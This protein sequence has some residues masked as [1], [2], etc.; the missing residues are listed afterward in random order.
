MSPVVHAGFRPA[1]RLRPLLA[2]LCAAAL[3]ALGACSGASPEPPLAGAA[4]GGDFTLIDK[5]GKTV[6]AADFAGRYRVVYF[7]YTF[8]PDVCPLD[9]QHLMQGVHAFAK[10]QPALGAKLAPM[11]ITIDPARDTPQV[12]GEFAANFG[13]ELIGLTGTPA[14]VA[15]VAKSYAVFYQKGKETAPG[16]YLMD[17]SRAAFLMGPEGQPIAILPAEA[18]GKAVAAELEKWVH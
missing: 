16:A 15:A 3:T 11:F 5:Q 13:P 18:D 1:H 7:G 12:V 4:I 14:Q 17:H 8:C 6:R 9:V 2:A 10:A